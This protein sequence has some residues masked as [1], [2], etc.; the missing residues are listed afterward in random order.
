MTVFWVRGTGDFWW[1][2]EGGREGGGE[3]DLLGQLFGYS[4]DVLVIESL[5]AITPQSI[6]LYTG[7]G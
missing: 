4:R 5:L 6:V 7:L 3:Q 1:A 2:W